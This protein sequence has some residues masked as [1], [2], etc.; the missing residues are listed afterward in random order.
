[1]L[2]LQTDGGPDHSIKRFMTKLALIATFCELSVD[3]LV[4]IRCAAN[5]SA[6]NKVE[7]GMSILN[8]PLGHP[9]VKRAEIPE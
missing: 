4:V 3:H 6:A 2:V 9:S 7:R 1:M 5:G 8:L